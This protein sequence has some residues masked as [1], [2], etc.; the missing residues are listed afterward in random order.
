VDEGGVVLGGGV[1]QSLGGA[2]CIV[3]YNHFLRQE[4]ARGNNLYGFYKITYN[5]CPG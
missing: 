4:N 1:E 2:V 5:M 3:N